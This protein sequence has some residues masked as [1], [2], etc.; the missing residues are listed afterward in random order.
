MERNEGGQARSENSCGVY[1]TIIG[2]FGNELSNLK[3]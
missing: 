2:E 3:L 1:A